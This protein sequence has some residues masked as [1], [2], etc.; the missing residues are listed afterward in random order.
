MMA[1]AEEKPIVHL[2]F[3]KLNGSTVDAK[4]IQ[5]DTIIEAF[6]ALKNKIEGLLKLEIG[7]NCVDH[8]DAWDIS[9]YM[10]FASPALLDLYQAN[11]MH[12]D[13]KKLVGP[14]RLDRGQVDFELDFNASLNLKEII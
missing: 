3:W 1:E 7:Q 5:A 8:P 4:K 2:V 11:P 14:M 12:L 13:I 9:F 6:L 10:V